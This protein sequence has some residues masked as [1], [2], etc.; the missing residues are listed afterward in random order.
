MARGG[1]VMTTPWIKA[2]AKF[3]WRCRSLQCNCGRR[4]KREKGRNPSL[5]GVIL[6]CDLLQVG[7]KVIWGR[8][9][10]VD[11]VQPQ[12]FGVGNNPHNSA[13]VNS[14]YIVNSLKFMWLFDP[15]Q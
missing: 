11:D 12:S 9:S 3:P 1:K 13:V 5:I 15:F 2:S 7:C 8:M 4:K 14:H 6:G 10:R